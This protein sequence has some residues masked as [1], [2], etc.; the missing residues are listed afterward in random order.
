[1]VTYVTVETDEVR[2]FTYGGIPTKKLA[3]Q[4]GSNSSHSA[5]LFQAIVARSDDGDESMDEYNFRDYPSLR[6]DSKKW[7]YTEK[8]YTTL[9][10]IEEREQELDYRLVTADDRYDFNKAD[11]GLVFVEH[12]W[13]KAE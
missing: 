4:V 7:N 5:R 1:M 12:I 8:E 3:Q 9:E 13:K 10:S 11:S 2:V 6:E